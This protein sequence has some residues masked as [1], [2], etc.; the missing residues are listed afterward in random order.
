MP[1]YRT[2]IDLTNAI[3]AD[4]YY[5]ETVVETHPHHDFRA[6]IF[7]RRW[8]IT[9]RWYEGV[10]PINFTATPR[11]VARRGQAHPR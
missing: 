11:R 7:K 9:G 8:D 6:R 4:G 1:D 5:V 2:V 3:S 10:F